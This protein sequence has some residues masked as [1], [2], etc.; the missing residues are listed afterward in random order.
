[1]LAFMMNGELLH[2]DHGYPVR[3]LMPGYIGGRMIKWLS[4][5]SVTAEEGENHYH[6]FDNRVFPKHIASKDI[7]TAEG[8]WK[9]PA[10][11]IND[12]NINSAIWAPAHCAKVTVSDDMYTVRGYAYAGAGRPVHRV[13]VETRVRR[14]HVNDSQVLTARAYDAQGNVF[15][16][17]EGRHTPEEFDCYREAGASVHLDDGEILA[18]WA[19]FA[20]ADVAVLARSSFSWAPAMLNTNCVVF[21]KN[22]RLAPVPG[23]IEARNQWGAEETWE[24]G[25][26]SQTLTDCIARVSRGRGATR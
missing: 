13:E 25:L 7:A 17:L 12:R 16:S 24:E 1:M 22:P 20:R 26:D 3:L 21:Q 10:Y 6:V 23:W 19:Y 18:P 2:P 5:I 11:T 4:A 9:D 15:S 14:I 8:I